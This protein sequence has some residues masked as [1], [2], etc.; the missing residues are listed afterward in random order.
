[1]V[2]RVRRALKIR[3][4]ALQ[5][6]LANFSKQA[7]L[8]IGS[9]GPTILRGSIR[10]KKRC[11]MCGRLSI[12]RAVTMKSSPFYVVKVHGWQS[13]VGEDSL[14]LKLLITIS[15]GFGKKGGQSH[16]VR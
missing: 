11:G 8:S 7:D 10:R 16:K 5:L 13:K 6:T 4:P 15:E 3:R 12:T 9:L 1:M 14:H 2:A